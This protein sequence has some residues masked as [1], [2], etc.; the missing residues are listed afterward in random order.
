MRQ[1]G[2]WSPLW[3]SLSLA[4]ET[5]AGHRGTRHRL[6]L[7]SGWNRD[8]P[9]MQIRTI[10]QI[11]ADEAFQYPQA[12]VTLPQAKRVEEEGPVPAGGVGAARA[13]GTRS[14][15]VAAVGGPSNAEVPSHADCLPE[16]H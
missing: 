9:R 10:E 1:R 5:A 8:Y 6:L 11:L 14:R 15:F 7:L 2:D 13:S 4:H 3:R 16:R 12:S